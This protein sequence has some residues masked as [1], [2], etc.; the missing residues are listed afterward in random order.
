MDQYE[1]LQLAIKAKSEKK[2]IKILEDNMN[3]ELKYILVQA[4]SPYISYG[5]DPESYDMAQPIKT[6][7]VVDEKWKLLTHIVYKL[8]TRGL[9]GQNAIDAIEEASVHFNKRQQFILDCILSKDLHCGVS[10]AVILSKLNLLPGFQAQ[11]AKERSNTTSP[12]FPCIAELKRSGVRNIS[13][14]NKDT[15][16]HFSPEGTPQPQFSFLNRELMNFSA[17]SALV[18][19]GTVHGVSKDSKKALK[20]A[21]T[22]KKPK[23]L[24]YTINDMMP[25]GAWARKACGAKQIQR[26]VDLKNFFNEYHN[27]PNVE[28]TQIFREAFV[29]IAEEKDAEKFLKKAKKRGYEGIVLKDPEGMYNFVPSYDWQIMR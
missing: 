18:L 13:I 27:N 10:S 25:M 15:V 28:D 29:P 20:M 6:K 26:T 12:T 5:V 21:E 24:R 23:S 11:T 14:I 3:Q 9:S 22:C 8:S 19:D 1:V 7:S 4:L 17:G 16:S 2:T